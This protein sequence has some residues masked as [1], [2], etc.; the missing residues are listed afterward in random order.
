TTFKIGPSCIRLGSTLVSSKPGKVE[1]PVKR[2]LA[3]LHILQ[4]TQNGAGGDDSNV[5][6]GTLIGQYTVYYADGSSE[7]IFII[8]GED[9]RDWWNWDMSKE[10]KRGKIAWTGSSP[11]AKAEDVDV[12]LYE[13]SWANPKPDVGIASITFSSAMNTPCAPFCIALSAQ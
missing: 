11:A 10:T 12:R 5:E 1:I 4:G 3:K 2:K 6:D 9:V 13:S 8:Y 7:G